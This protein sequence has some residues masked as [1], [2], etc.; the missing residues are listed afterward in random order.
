[1][2]LSFSSSAEKICALLLHIDRI[3]ASK[4]KK[5][6]KTR[7]LVDL[8]VFDAMF[9]NTIYKLYD[10]YEKIDCAHYIINPSRWSCLTSLYCSS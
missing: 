4:R 7:D 10:A 3:A 1:M 6:D 5:K 8:I 9:T 2:V